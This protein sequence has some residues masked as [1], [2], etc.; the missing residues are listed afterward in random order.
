MK[1]NL[2]ND[3][4]NG[5]GRQGNYH[6]D[7]ACRNGDEISWNVSNEYFVY[8]MW[9]A[10]LISLLSLFIFYNFSDK[11]S[12]ANEVHYNKHMIRFDSRCNFLPYLNHYL[13][14]L[15]TS[16]IFVTR[17]WYFCNIF[18]WHTISIYF[19]NLEIT[20]NKSHYII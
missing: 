2:G 3:C 17:L 9:M 18:E 16:Y 20:K 1:A 4:V 5:N 13:S 15:M 10:C 11:L 12:V 8:N 19:Y 6:F 14:R 7:D